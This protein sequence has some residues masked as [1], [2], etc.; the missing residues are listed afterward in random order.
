MTD[1]TAVGTLAGRLGTTRF[2]LARLNAA[3]ELLFD[4]LRTPAP[5]TTSGLRRYFTNWLMLIPP[6]KTARGN[7]SKRVPYGSARHAG[8]VPFVKS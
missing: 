4:E 3:T 6:P 2:A 1:N 8:R 7:C 5:K